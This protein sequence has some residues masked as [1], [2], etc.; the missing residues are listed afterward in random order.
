MRLIDYISSKFGGRKDM[1]KKFKCPSNY[2]D[3]FKKYEDCVGSCENCWNQ[4]ME[5]QDEINR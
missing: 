2:G 3:E 5:E 4:K 1:I